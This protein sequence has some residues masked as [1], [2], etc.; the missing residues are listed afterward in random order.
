MG[1]DF[2]IPH[3]PRTLVGGAKI[4]FTDPKDR[5]IYDSTMQAYFNQIQANNNGG[6]TSTLSDLKAALSPAGYA[7]LRNFIQGQKKFMRTQIQKPTVEAVGEG[8]T[9]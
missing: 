2:A 8:V 3:E 6:P 7:Q 9:P 1:Q 5:A 4:G